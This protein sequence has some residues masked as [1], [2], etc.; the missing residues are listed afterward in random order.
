M[1]DLT[2]TCK[3]VALWVNKFGGSSHAKLYSVKGVSVC[4][5]YVCVFQH[6]QVV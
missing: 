3:F 4:G 1:H 2:H 6:E 5:M